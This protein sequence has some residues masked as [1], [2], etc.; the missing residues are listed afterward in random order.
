M[1]SSGLNVGLRAAEAGEDQRGL[2]VND[3][4]AV[5]VGRD[6][7]RHAASAQCLPS[8]V[9]V[10]S[11]GGKIPTHAEKKSHASLGHGLDGVDGREAVM[12]RR[13]EAE[14]LFQAGEKFLLGFLGDAHGAVTLDIAVS[15]NG[16]CSGTRATDVSAQQKKVHHLLNVGD[17]VAVLGEPHRPATNHRARAEI[18]LRR[19]FNLL[20]VESTLLEENLPRSF[21]DEAA[22]FLE[23]VRVA[24]QKIMIEDRAVG[25]G[26][27]QNEFRHRA[28]GGHVAS[29]LNLVVMRAD[30]RA[31]AEEHVDGILG[32]REIQET[33]FLERIETHNPRAA[34]RG[35]LQLGEHARVVGAGI[36]AEDKDC[37]GFFKILE[38]HSAFASSNRFGHP[39]AAR[40]VAHVRAVG[41]IVRP[42]KPA[43]ELVK[44]R[45]LVA[46]AAGGVERRI[47]GRAERAQVPRDAFERLVPR[48]RLIAV[49]VG[50]VGH[51]VREPSG[52]LEREVIP[53]E[54]LGNG[55]FRKKLGRRALGGRFV[56][57]GLNAI[58]AE[59]RGGRIFRVRPGAAGTIE[60]TRLVHAEEGRVAFEETFTAEEV[61][62]GIES[63]PSAGFGFLFS[64][65][66]CRVSLRT[67]RREILG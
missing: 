46:G 11:G 49:G 27:F 32:M 7:D 36:L 2:S 37:V 45:R 15:A 53:S 48:N 8:K 47:V 64:H 30:R 6:M 23:S 41:E 38:R 24:L 56:G 29:D 20:A 31:A 44:E 65:G 1:P 12:A 55:V 10:G 61:Q 4:A 34:L 67:G 14:F 40:L 26:F 35:F 25:L 62:G 59:F 5:Q 43:E 22:I 19:F 17:S 16:A 51:R 42:E 28:D 21:R 18:D 3:M 39:D 50:I 52:I 57:Q 13:G 33:R 60:A 9:G 63:S 54:H 66:L 58:L